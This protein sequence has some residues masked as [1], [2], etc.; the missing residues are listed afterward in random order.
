M[1]TFT[2]SDAECKF[3]A[4]LLK[5]AEKA[6]KVPKASKKTEKKKSVGKP[7]KIDDCKT[8]KELEKF[9]IKELIAWLEQN[10]ICTKKVAK[11][12]KPTWVKLVWENLQESD[13]SDDSSSDS[14][15][16]GSDSESDCDSESDSD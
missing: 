7:A 4:S 12:V 10:E 5:K 3:L 14:G 13:S 2:L 6:A 11:K 16:S 8:K 9:T 15:D 1:A